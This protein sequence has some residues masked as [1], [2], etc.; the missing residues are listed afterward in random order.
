MRTVGLAEHVD[1]IYYS[2]QIGA[3]K[4]GQDFF[5]KVASTM[6][7]PAGEILLVDDSPDNTR[8]AQAAGWKAI[9]WTGEKSLTETWGEMREQEK[10][11]P[12]LS[13]LHQAPRL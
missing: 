3:R 5:D 9:H 6:G 11:A 4:P 1:G 12:E 7:F 2:A 10:P 13:S 8:A